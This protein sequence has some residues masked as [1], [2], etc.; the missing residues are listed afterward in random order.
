MNRFYFRL[1]ALAVVLIISGWLYLSEERDTNGN[2]E[3]KANKEEV[4][5]A[6]ESKKDLIVVDS[7][8]PFSVITS[9][10]T[11]SGKARGYWFFEGDFPVSITD[12]EGSVISKW[13]ATAVLDPEDPES[14]WMTEDFVPFKGSIEFDLTEK[15]ISEGVVIFHKDNPSDLPEHD[16]QLEIPVYFR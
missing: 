14:T 2:E 3:L 1:I 8:A 15:I 16:D 11:V 5:R 12:S 7:P 4:L 9:P 13:Y 6:I 10:L